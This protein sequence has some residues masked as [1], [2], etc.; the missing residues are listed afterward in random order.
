MIR[1]IKRRKII[2]FS[3]PDSNGL[4]RRLNTGE[5]RLY[6]RRKAGK[7]IIRKSIGTY[8]SLAVAKKYEQEI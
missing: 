3:A 4:I 7:N 1:G 6:Y 2:L 8:S 5:Y